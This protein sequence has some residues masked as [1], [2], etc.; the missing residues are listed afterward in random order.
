MTVFLLSSTRGFLPAVFPPT[1]RPALPHSRHPRLPCFPAPASISWMR[2]LR[3]GAGRKRHPRRVLPQK[4]HLPH[5]A[6]PDVPAH[7]LPQVEHPRQ[8]CQRSF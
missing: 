8:I 5:V 7:H 2:L 1:V 3:F 6:Q 4:Q